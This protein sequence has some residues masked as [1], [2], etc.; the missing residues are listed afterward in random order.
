M[1]TNDILRRIRFLLKL[2]DARLLNLLNSS[3]FALSPDDLDRYLAREDEEHFALC[4][5]EVVARFLDAVIGLKRGPSADPR[6]PELPLTNNQV[7]KKLRVAFSLKDH[8]IV[9]LMQSVGFRVGKSE[10]NALFRKPDQSNYRVCGDQ[11][12]RQFLKALTR[13]ERPDITQEC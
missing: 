13:K 10:I 5:D 12:L 8:D 1:L 7:L 9:E 6:A 4:P 2:S 11:F 3:D